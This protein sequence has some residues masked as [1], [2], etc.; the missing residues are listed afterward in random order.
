MFFFCCTDNHD[1]VVRFNNAPVLGYEKD[2]GRKT[3]LRILNS[4]ILSKPKFQFVNASLY[5]NIS[6]VVWDPSAH[7]SSLEQVS[8]YCYVAGLTKTYFCLFIFYTLV[9]PKS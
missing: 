7:N 9:G 1:Y 6:L 4:Q 5:H 3:S 8:F 2:V